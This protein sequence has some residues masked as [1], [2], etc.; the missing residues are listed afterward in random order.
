MHALQPQPFDDP[1]HL[2]QTL[3]VEGSQALI[4]QLRDLVDAYRRRLSVRVDA[5]P[6]EFA[7]LASSVL[8][9]LNKTAPRARH[10]VAGLVPYDLHSRTPLYWVLFPSRDNQTLWRFAEARLGKKAHARHR[11][12]QRTQSARPGRAVHTHPDVYDWGWRYED[13]RRKEVRAQPWEARLAAD[14]EQAVTGPLR[15]ALRAARII[16]KYAN[17]MRPIDAIGVDLD[18]AEAHLCAK[19]HVAP[20]PDSYVAPRGLPAIVW[21]THSASIL[22]EDPL[23]RR[24]LLD[25]LSAPIESRLRACQM[26]YT[27]QQRSCWGVSRPAARN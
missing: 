1:S 24:H 16:E 10:R 2:S 4:Q 9:Y 7:A 5:C 26:E 25:L 22:P 11:K 23:A 15:R 18:R 17:E 14:F 13:F 8:D 21:D 6:A 12:V 27:P 20:A 3:T 19:L